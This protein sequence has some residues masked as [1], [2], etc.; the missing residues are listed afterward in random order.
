MGEIVKDNRSWQTQYKTEASF[1]AGR[2]K[3]KKECIDYLKE[4]DG[5]LVLTYRRKVVDGVQGYEVITNS[6]MAK[7]KCMKREISR[8]LIQALSR[9]LIQA[10]MEILKND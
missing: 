6:C 4:S 2:N 9:R 3:R 10:S 7:D 5:F 1:L 8:R